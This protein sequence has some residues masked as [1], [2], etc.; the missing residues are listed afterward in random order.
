MSLTVGRIGVTAANGGDG[1]T[2]DGPENVNQQGRQ[3]TIT[4]HVYDTTR[5]ASVWRA[6]QILG[7]ADGDEPV[8]PCT[9]SEAPDL[10]GYYRVLGATCDYQ[11]V[12]ST[13]ANSHIPWEIQLEQ[14]A[15]FRQPQIELATAFGVRTNGRSITAVDAV[16]AY[17]GPSQAIKSA[18]NADTSGSRSVGDGSGNAVVYLQDSG[19]STSGYAV[20]GFVSEAADFYIGGCRIEH[21]IGSGT[22][23]HCVGRPDFPPIDPPSSSRLRLQNGLMRATFTY[24]NATVTDWGV[25]WWD[26][27]QWDTST[28]F[29]IQGFGDHGELS[30]L[31]PSV[32]YNTA[33]GCAVRFRV[34]GANLS[35]GLTHVDFSTRRGSRWLTA[36]VR[37]DLSPT[38]GWRAMFDS[39]VATTTITGGLR[40]TS[41][42]GGGNREL[43]ASATNAT[44]DNTNGRVTT[45]S[46]SQETFGF[47]CEVAGSSATGQNTA[48]NQM[49]EWFAAVAERA[50][51]VAN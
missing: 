14:I 43:I 33:E 46:I 48:A 40:R 17:P 16:Q 20:G 34:I 15:N 7:L 45:T 11:K 37:G 9:F 35:Q 29:Q 36:F 5:A 51:V 8:V 32:L 6:K 21:D 19:M 2:F 4:G 44:N 18:L 23:R 13:S 41:N 38:G 3:F 47:G 12:G 24:G 22:Y 25:E 39:S 1:L 26:G 31:S 50:V 42:N 28:T 49:E 27:S 30:L 10:D